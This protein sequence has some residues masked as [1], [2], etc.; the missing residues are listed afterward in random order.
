MNEKGTDVLQ[1]YDLDIIRTSRVRGA[2]LCE[3][4]QGCRLLKEYRGSEARLCQVENA[5]SALEGVSGIA[6]DRVIPNREGQLISVDADQTAY[7]V[8]EW[9]SGRECDLTNEGEVLRGVRLL[10]MLHTG[11]RQVF[12]DE[13]KEGNNLKEEYERRTA[14]LRRTRSYVRRVRNKSEFELCMMRSFSMFFEQA[15]EALR[16]LELEEAGGTKPQKY[17][18]HGEYS[19]HHILYDGEFAMITDFLGM[20]RGVQAGDL[21]YFMRKAMEKRGFC[22]RTGERILEEYDRYLPLTKEERHYLYIRFLYPEKYW[23]QINYYYN[24]N[25]A[26]IPQRN[27]DKLKILE[28]QEPERK[29]FLDFLHRSVI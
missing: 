20:L 6:V 23:K 14:G 22:C 2:V 18:C 28:E 26:W 10:A 7:I 25:K 27:T 8:K 16:Q 11:L 4:R 19:H 9:N 5:L 13:C 15:E 21:Y 17:L 24:S 1:Q 29:K 3:T 12:G